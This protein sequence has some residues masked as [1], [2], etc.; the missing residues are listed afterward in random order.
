MWGLEVLLST[1]KLA[2]NSPVAPL[3]FVVRCLEDGSISQIPVCNLRK[4][5]TFRK[6]MKIVEVCYEAINVGFSSTREYYKT[7]SQK[8]RSSSPLCGTMSGR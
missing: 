4:F 8:P 5:P 3:H 2:T 6:K 1:T 7:T